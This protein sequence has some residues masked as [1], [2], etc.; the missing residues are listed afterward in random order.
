MDFGKWKI[1]EAIA[2][3]ILGDGICSPSKGSIFIASLSLIF[4]SNT[5]LLNNN[6]HPAFFKVMSKH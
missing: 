5:T 6:Q 4:K 1:K 3:V 2:Y